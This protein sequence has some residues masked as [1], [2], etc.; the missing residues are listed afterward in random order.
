[1]LKGQMKA[2]P[3]GDE[4]LKVKERQKYAEDEAKEGISE[5]SGDYKAFPK[6]IKLNKR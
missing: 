1:M 2:L 5:S 6:N 4:G 3:D